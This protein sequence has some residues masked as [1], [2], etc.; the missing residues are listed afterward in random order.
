MNTPPTATPPKR[1]KSRTGEERPV[2]PESLRE[3]SFGGG[4]GMGSEAV[5]VAGDEPVPVELSGREFCRLGNT[6]P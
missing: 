4:S 3:D 1:R 2:D 5:S 6:G